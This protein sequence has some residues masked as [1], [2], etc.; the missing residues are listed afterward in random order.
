MFNSG[1]GFGIGNAGWKLGHQMGAGNF[2]IGN[3]DGTS[4][5]LFNSE[6]SSTGNGPGWL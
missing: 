1:G 5:G 6:T 3:A 2:G 4:T